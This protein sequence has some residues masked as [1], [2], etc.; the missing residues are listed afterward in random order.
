MRGFAG[1]GDGIGSEVGVLVTVFVGVRFIKKAFE[2]FHAQ[3]ATHGF[4]DGR[5]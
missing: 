2:K 5:W 3:D 4:V 1:E